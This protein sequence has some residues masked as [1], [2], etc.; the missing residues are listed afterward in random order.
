MA[1]IFEK[2]NINTNEVL[3]AASTKWNFIKYKPG[4]VGG[5]CIGVDPYYLA[6]K[7]ESHGYYPEVILSG[8]RINDRMGSFVANK[9]IKLMISKNLQIFNSKILILGI[10]FKENCPDIRNT[11]VLDIYKEL[12]EFGCIVDI[13]D[14]W[15]N[16][17]EVKNELGIELI[18]DFKNLQLEMYNGIILAVSHNEFLNL[19]LEN[20]P[21]RAIYDVKGFLPNGIADATL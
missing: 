17:E 4:L 5:H 1:L 16:K 7:A 14:Y 13:C 9:L 12:I 11:K 19:Q 6:H 2:L 8:R 3:E 21:K 20:L 15:A 18:D 10:T